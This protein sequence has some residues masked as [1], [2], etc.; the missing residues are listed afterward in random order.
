MEDPTKLRGGNRMT[1]AKKLLLLIT[2]VTVAGCSSRS[3][4]SRLNV[5]S[6]FNP[7]GDYGNYDTYGWVDYGTDQMVIKDPKVRQRVVE[8]IEN[9]M[10]SRGLKYDA[11]APDLLIGYHGA[12]ERKLDEAVVQTYYDE[13][14]YDMDNS[15]WKKIESFEVGTLVLL[16]FDAKDGNMLWR[17]SA[18]AELDEKASPSQQKKNIELAVQRM[19]ETLPTERDVQDAIE[20]KGNR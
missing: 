12:V 15:P 14:N 3:L 8:A 4:E 11:V 18:Q 20:Q 17:A 19:L 6:Y 7:D 13:A 10:E 16:I 1:F 9:E 2:I 5:E